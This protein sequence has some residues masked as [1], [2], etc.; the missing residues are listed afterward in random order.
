MESE[1]PRTRSPSSFVARMISSRAFFADG[2][3]LGSVDGDE[4]S[5]ER[6]GALIDLR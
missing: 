4:A 1:G 3:S 6:G 2:E 5:N